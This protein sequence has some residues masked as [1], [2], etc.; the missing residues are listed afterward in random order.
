MAAAEESYSELRPG[1]FAT[2]PHDAYCDDFGVNNTATPEGNFSASV[3]RESP[4][5]FISAVQ[6]LGQRLL[7]NSEEMERRMAEKFQAQIDQLNERIWRLDNVAAGRKGPGRQPET[8]ARACEPE[9][10]QRGD[11]NRRFPE[12]PLISSA[13]FD[14]KSAWDDYRVQ[15]ELIADLNGWDE[16]TKAIYLAASLQGSAQAIL[17]DL[18]DYARRNYRALTEALSTRFGNEGQTQLFRTQLKHRARGK[19]E[20]LPELAQAIRRLVR[21]AYPNASLAIQDVLVKD[22]FIDAITDSEMRWHVVHSRPGTVQEALNIATELEAFQVS[23]RQRNRVNRHSAYAVS[24]HV[25]EKQGTSIESTLI[26]ILQ[27]IKRDREEQKQLLQEFVRR[28]TDFSGSGRRSVSHSRDGSREIQCW[29][30]G[31]LGHVSL[32]CRRRL[33]QSGDHNQGNGNGLNLRA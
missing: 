18:D 5:S 19:D 9:I 8:E 17:A 25:V 22:H 30:C 10:D 28:M 15:F 29:N 1:S 27:E 4:A 2:D 21:Q 31:E 20:S 33:S 7:A 14:G 16:A 32:E 23:E 3:G 12:K 11:R 26:D 13:P 6:E 24:S